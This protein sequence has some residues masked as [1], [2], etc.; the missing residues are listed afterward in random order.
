MGS[1]LQDQLLKAGLVSEQQVKQARSGK[2]RGR[3]RGQPQVRDEALAAE[4]E[5]ERRRERDRER[6]R[7]IEAERERKA[8]RARAREL[9]RGARLNDPRAEI[10][11]HFIH[12]KQVKR[13]YVTAEQQA[14]L[15]AGR[16]A[17]AALATRHHLVT[18]EVADKA[19]AMVPDLFVFRADRDAPGAEEA[20]EYAEHPIP[21]DL[22]W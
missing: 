22:I 17:I 11:Y 12:G 5:R 1:S 21:D 8:S 7:A 20:A 15:A 18:I 16:L 10:P 14:A 2:R 6:N 19:R 4:R 9:L 13:I 3:R